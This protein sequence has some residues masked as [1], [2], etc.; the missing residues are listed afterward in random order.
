VQ[1]VPQQPD[2]SASNPATTQ[3][4]AARLILDI[5]EDILAFPL[6]AFKIE[7]RQQINPASQGS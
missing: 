5:M 1:N 4:I 7:R 3:S 2:S 6:T